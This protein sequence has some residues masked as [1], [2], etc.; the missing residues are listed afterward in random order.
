MEVIGFLAPWILVGIGV[1][2]VSFSGG[3]G[4]AREAYLTRGR[5]VFGLLI[6]LTYIGIGI[7]VPAVV[8]ASRGEK[9]GNDAALSQKTVRDQPAYVERGRQLFIENCAA[10]HNLDAVNARGVTGPDLDKIGTVTP[11]RVESAIRIGGTGQGRMP[12][13]LLQGDNAKAVAEY[14][15]RVAGK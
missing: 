13:G 12:A 4:A 15:A 2:F 5:R 3:P 9:E 14:V 10:C 1:I 8:I 11:G 6:V 7:A